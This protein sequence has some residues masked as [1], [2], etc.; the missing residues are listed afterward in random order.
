M[1]A[2]VALVALT[3]LLASCSTQAEVWIA[4]DGSGHGEL[5][6]SDPP[7]MSAAELRRHLERNGFTIVDT[8]R[9]DA[10]TFVANVGWQEF[11]KPFR[12]RTLNADGSITVDFGEMVDGTLTVHVPGALDANDT[13]GTVDG[14]SARFNGGRAR[15]T[16]R[17]G[18]DRAWLF[19]AVGG[20]TLLV[21]LVAAFIAANRRAGNPR[22]PA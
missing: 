10:R 9:R 5:T 14:R 3:L 21:V 18:L 22:T 13:T 1:R 12:A 8:Q 7:P 4:N 2:L 20:I 19:L 11:T 6:L 17:P 15:L 16:Y